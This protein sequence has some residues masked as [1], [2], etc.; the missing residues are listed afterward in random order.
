M[1]TISEYLSIITQLIPGIRQVEIIELYSG[2]QA[3]GGVGATTKNALA[4]N[5]VLTRSSG[6]IENRAPNFKRRLSP[7]PSF[8]K[9]SFDI[10]IFFLISSFTGPIR[11]CLSLV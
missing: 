3:P 6:S 7:T 4:W 11:V 10:E 5:P 9:V 1:P 2:S 8:I